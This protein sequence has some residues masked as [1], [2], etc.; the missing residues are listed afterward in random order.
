[1]TAHP[2]EKGQ[3]WVAFVSCLAVLA[4]VLA[5]VTELAPAFSAK[6]A[7]RSCLD[8]VESELGL[9]SSVLVDGQGTTA[10]GPDTAQSVARR[11]VERC[12]EAGFAGEVTVWFY[13][14]P[15]NTGKVDANDRLWAWE[16]HLV[17]TCPTRLSGFTGTD[18]IRVESATCGTAN[19]YARERVFR[20]A[21]S[22]MGQAACYVSDSGS[23]LSRDASVGSFDDMPQGLKDAYGKSMDGLRAS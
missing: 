1:M 5:I 2:N 14:A 21:T 19:P 4:I 11:A 18:G 16:V 9:P 12:R 20:S 3:V 13:E 17:E 6:V 23:S 22:Q 7:Q 8:C 10:S 15:E